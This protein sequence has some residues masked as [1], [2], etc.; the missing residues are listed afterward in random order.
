MDPSGQ[1]ANSYGYAGGNPVNFVDPSG[2]LTEGEKAAI[3]FGLGFVAYGACVAGAIATA[4]ICGVIGLAVGFAVDTISE[5]AITK[6]LALGSGG[7]FVAG[8]VCDRFVRVRGVCEAVGG[9]VGAVV[10]TMKGDKE[11]N[12]ERKR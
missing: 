10:G 1:D 8:K 9:A 11:K 7:G 5:R 12:K 2:L 3:Y 6:K 4:A